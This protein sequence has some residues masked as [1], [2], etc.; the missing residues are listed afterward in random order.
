MAQPDFG[1]FDKVVE[2][3][4]NFDNVG[5]HGGGHYSIGGEVLLPFS[6]V[7]TQLT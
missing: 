3:A 1:W 7:K 6:K 4:P 2:G 5:I